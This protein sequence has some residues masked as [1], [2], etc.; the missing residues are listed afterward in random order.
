MPSAKEPCVSCKGMSR[1]HDSSTYGLIPLNLCEYSA[2]IYFVEKHVRC[3][4]VN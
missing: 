3:K 4:C 1:P 2:N